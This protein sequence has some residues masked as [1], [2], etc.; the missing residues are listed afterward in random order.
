MRFSA[1][2]H[3]RRPWPLYLISIPFFGVG[4]FCKSRPIGMISPFIR[5][6]SSIRHGWKTPEM[7]AW[8]TPKMLLTSLGFPIHALCWKCFAWKARVSAS[9]FNNSSADLLHGQI[10]NSGNPLKLLL[11]IPCPFSVMASTPAVEIFLHSAKFWRERGLGGA[12]ALCPL[13]CRD[14]RRETRKMLSFYTNFLEC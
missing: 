2:E 3:R 14:Y 8:E 10:R 6:N 13:L 7:C 5:G 11:S 1:H 4:S 12:A 9:R